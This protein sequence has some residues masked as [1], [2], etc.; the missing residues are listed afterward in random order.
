MTCPNCKKVY[1]DRVTI[2]ISCGAELVPDVNEEKTE[3]VFEA[4]QPANEEEIPVRNISLTQSPV[5][6]RAVP[7][8][9]VS[10]DGRNSKTAFSKTLLRGI[11]AV[12]LFVSVLMLFLSFTLRQLTME[13]NISRAVKSFDL[14]GLPVSEFIPESSG[15]TI[16]EAVAVMANGTGLDSK[17]IQS[18]YESSTIKEH[19]C[20]I[21]GQYGAYL[22]IG[23]VPETVT[24]ETV[25]NLFNENISVINVWT[26]YVISENDRA[27]AYKYIDSMSPFIN[28]F[29]VK[30]IESTSGDAVSFVRAFISVPVIIAEIVLA[31]LSAVIYA[32]TS[33][34]SERTLAF[35]GTSLLTAG[36]VILGFVFMFTMQIGIF[37]FSGPVLRELVKSVSYAMSDMMY[38]IGGMITVFGV[39]ALVWSA[40]LRRKEKQLRK[41]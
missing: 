37:D 31:V 3:G 12:V 21:L 18:V 23:T 25:K 1:N 17:A 16:G 35:A 4:E 36:V 39:G 33:G 14:L 30:A 41:S 10:E 7:L 8:N 22:R 40:T 28:A 11:A 26:G 29:S 5:T 24:A 32:V 2:C 38:A 19:M 34:S 9:D 13:Q 27:L 6:V 15:V 20:R